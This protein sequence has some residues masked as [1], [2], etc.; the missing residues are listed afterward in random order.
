MGFGLRVAATALFG[1]LMLTA[2]TVCN[3]QASQRFK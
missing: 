1:Q 3:V 2:L